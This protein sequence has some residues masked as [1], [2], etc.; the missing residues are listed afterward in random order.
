MRIRRSLAGKPIGEQHHAAKLTEAQV[1]ELRRLVH[2]V[3]LCTRC[4][5]KV[6]A[7]NVSAQSAY[8][9]AHFYTWKHVQ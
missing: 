4:A 6:V 2:D 3:G 5:N 9:A 1:R 8:E 7:P